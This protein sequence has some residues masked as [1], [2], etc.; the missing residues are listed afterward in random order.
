MRVSVCDRRLCLLSM[1]FL[2]LAISV[3]FV[4]CASPDGSV[5]ASDVDR[6]IGSVSAA[7]RVRDSEQSMDDLHDEDIEVS[8]EDE[9]G[10]WLDAPNVRL[11]RAKRRL[12]V[13]LVSDNSGSQRETL[14]MVQSS[15]RAF[16]DE[17]LAT[18][19]VSA[20]VRV[21]VVRVST[22][23]TVLSDLTTDSN[24]LHRVVDQMYAADGWTALWD[25]V[26]MANEVLAR[27]DT[28]AL[29]EAGRVC[30]SPVQR[31]IVVFTDG[32]DNNSRDEHL[33]RFAGDGVNTTFDDLLALQVT[34]VRTPVFTIGVGRSMDEPALR[35][36]A[37]A[38]GGGYARIADFRGLAQALGAV[39][40]GVKGAVPVC[41]DLPEGIRGVRVRYTVNRRGERSTVTAPLP[42]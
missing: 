16:I 9:H 10:R 15:A 25:G 6:G 2:V 21:G 42:N 32:K 34:N 19:N 27:G 39:A 26:R 7:L 37:G 24:D 23:A 22:N 36:I 13:V 14:P 8:V 5:V 41:F 31:A 28:E 12:D 40:H 20:S 30:S 35:Q 17:L 11:I 38:S 33:T 3:A 18:E 29:R 1:R 4:A